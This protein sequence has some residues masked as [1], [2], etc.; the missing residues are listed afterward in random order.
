MMSDIK[1]T[2]E[3]WF[4]GSYGNLLIVGNY[5][6]EPDKHNVIA[7][8]GPQHFPSN[9]VEYENAERIIDCV[10]ACVGMENPAA[11]RDLTQQQAEVIAKLEMQCGDHEMAVSCLEGEV[12]ELVEYAKGLRDALEGMYLSDDQVG[13]AAAN[14]ILAKPMPKAMKGE[15]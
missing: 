13:A 1:H 7:S 12:A 5:K 6:G 15:E 4:Y 11:L 10:N 8:L 9:T 2:P 3:P 14:A